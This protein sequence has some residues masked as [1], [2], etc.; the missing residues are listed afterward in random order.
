MC[1]KA[2]DDTANPEG[3]IPERRKKKVAP[4]PVN[5]QTTGAPTGNI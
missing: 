2:G 4:K 3:M 5:A 1:S